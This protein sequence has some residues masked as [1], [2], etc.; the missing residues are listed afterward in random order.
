VAAEVEAALLPIGAGANLEQALHG[1]E[2]Y[3]LLFT[4]A[5]AAQLPKSIGGVAVRRIGK[6][7]R[8]S[9]GRPPVTLVTALGKR[10]LEPSGWEHFS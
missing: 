4:A 3:E 1:G 8:L 10:A 2:D 7:V 9:K 5:A 6:I